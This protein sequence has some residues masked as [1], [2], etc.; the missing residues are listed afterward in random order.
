MS[1]TTPTVLLVDDDAAVGTVLLALLIQ[2]GLAARHVGSGELALT[3]RGERP[4]SVG[5]TDL[6]MPG[7]VVMEL[8]KEIVTMKNN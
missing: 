4:I 7:M 8:H 1:D 3:A 2:A 6:S 5:V